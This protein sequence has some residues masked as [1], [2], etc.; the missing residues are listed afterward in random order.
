[1]AFATDSIDPKFE[2]ARTESVSPKESLAETA[3]K[4]THVN[5]NKISIGGRPKREATIS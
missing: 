4:R 2:R 3:I 1:M 5:R